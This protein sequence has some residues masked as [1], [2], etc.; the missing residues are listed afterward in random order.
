MLHT[1]VFIG[2][3]G[4]GKG[5]QAGLLRE[6]IVAN[7]EK[8]RQKV[9]VETGEHFRKFTRENTY[10]AQLSNKISQLGDR[11]PDFLACW[12]WGKILIEELDKDMHVIFDGAPRSLPEATVFA[13]ALKFYKREHPVI[14]HLNVSRKWSE[15]KLLARGRLDDRTI[16]DIDK[17]LDW[18]DRDTLPAIEY[19]KKTESYRVIEINGEQPLEGVH[20]DIMNAYAPT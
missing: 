20:A 10:S 5:T 4:C 18:F 12:M 6:W 11:Q 3:S 17:R 16:A 13:T 19:F 2:R 15:D 8:K 1:L 7:D 9:Y 14:I